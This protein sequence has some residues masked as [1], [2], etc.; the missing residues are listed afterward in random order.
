MGGRS[1]RRE[2]PQRG[3]GEGHAAG[4]LKKAVDHELLPQPVVQ[5]LGA[6]PEVVAS[7]EFVRLIVGHRFRPHAGKPRNPITSASATM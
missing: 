7:C 5:P 4:A 6:Q 2:F 3:C 1:T